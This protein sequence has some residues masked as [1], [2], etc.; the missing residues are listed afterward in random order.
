VPENTSQAPD[1]AE[2]ARGPAPGTPLAGSA[3]RVLENLGELEPELRAA[4][5]IGRDGA[6]LA[7]TGSEPEWS[8][9]AAE[10]L[11]ALDRAGGRE[12]DSAHLATPSGEIFVVREG[13]LALVAVTGRFVLASLTS[14]DI[15]MA[16]RDL[17]QEAARA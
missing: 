9:R 6:T 11:G 8:A 7:S 14:F 17:N 2:S 3:V 10:L 12:I 15:R 16:L 4:A 5:V 1:P 13:G